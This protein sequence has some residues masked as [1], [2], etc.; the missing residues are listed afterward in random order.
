LVNIQA[1]VAD[2]LAAYLYQE[3]FGGELGQVIVVGPT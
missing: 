2:F 3:F 1:P